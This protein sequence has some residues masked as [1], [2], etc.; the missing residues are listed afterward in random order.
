MTP[1]GEDPVERLRSA[2]IQLGAAIADLRSMPFRRHSQDEQAMHVGSAQRSLLE[3]DAELRRACQDLGIEP[4]RVSVDL[5]TIE[6]LGMLVEPILWE[7]I[8]GIHAIRDR[9]AAVIVSR[10]GVV[11]DDLEVGSPME[12]WAGTRAWA[13]GQIVVFAVLFVALLTSAIIVIYQ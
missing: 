13:I 4:I 10:G 9:V 11:P 6:P 2:Y 5:D 12:R 7:W 3:A 1:A 8:A